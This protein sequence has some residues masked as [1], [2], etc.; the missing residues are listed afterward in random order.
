M[1]DA[2]LAATGCGVLAAVGLRAVARW[3][4]APDR[5]V[6][7]VLAGTSGTLHVEVGG[8]RREALVYV[9]AKVAGPAPVVLAWHGSGQ[10]ATGFR[11][12]CGFRFDELADRYGFV[13]AYPE[14]VGP[15]FNDARAGAN[16]RARR[17]GVDDVAFARALVER[18]RQQ[19]GAGRVV[20]TGWSNG[21]QLSLRLAL[22]DPGLVDAIAVVAAGWPTAENLGCRDE[23]APMPLLVV[24]G[25]ADPMNPF[26]GGKVAFHGLGGRGAVLSS[27]E[28]ARVAAVRNGLDP[29]R[30]QRTAWPDAPGD[31]TRVIVTDIDPG[32]GAMVRHV[33]VV[34]GGHAY[35]APGVRNMRALGRSSTQLD[36]PLMVCELFLH[37]GL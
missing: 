28:T 5:P 10:S 1:R 26:E 18:L 27:V 23:R 12:M 7:P 24:N 17:E 9:P 30:V 33:E 6:R 32:G 19:Y 22:E 3:W 34:G 2:I 21:A 36:V 13:V 14:S 15:M 16:C 29:E 4:L 25:S 20:S 37:P 8:R 31:P 35:P 11:R